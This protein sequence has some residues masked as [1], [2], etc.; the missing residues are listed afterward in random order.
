MGDKYYL[1][2]RLEYLQ[3]KGQK[4]TPEGSCGRE[5]MEARQRSW[6]K[7]AGKTTKYSSVREQKA[8]SFY[9]DLSY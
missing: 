4:T 6:K 2:E 7:T 8:V 3:F 1:N 9:P 5:A